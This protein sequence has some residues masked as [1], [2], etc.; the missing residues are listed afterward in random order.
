MP[1]SFIPGVTALNLTSS[2]N[3]GSFD[4][5]NDLKKSSSSSASSAAARALD[6]F[7]ALPCDDVSAPLANPPKTS[8]SAS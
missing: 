4:G 2:T 3:L 7:R 6:F 8:A 1:S 5:A